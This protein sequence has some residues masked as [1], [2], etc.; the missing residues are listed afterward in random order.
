MIR[1]IQAAGGRSLP[2]MPA[3]RCGPTVK[4]DGSLLAPSR[5]SPTASIRSP[6]RYHDPFIPPPTHT[7]RRSLQATLR[8]YHQTVNPPRL[9]LSLFLSFFL[10]LSLFLSLP[11]SL[12]LPP[13][14]STYLSLYIYLYL[15]LSISEQSLNFLPLL[16]LRVYLYLYLSSSEQSLYLY[17]YLFS[18]S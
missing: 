14:L 15:Y 13:S 3:R 7:S 11:P 6:F 5:L 12:P 16:H 10:S 18:Q 8:S 1:H 9:L 2:L 4:F 17:L